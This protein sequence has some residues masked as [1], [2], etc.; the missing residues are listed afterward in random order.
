MHI[1]H[2]AG[3]FVRAIVQSASTLSNSWTLS[4]DGPAAMMK[5]VENL[6]A[7]DINGDLTKALKFLKNVPYEK[8]VRAQT[9]ILIEMV[10]FH[11]MD[12]SCS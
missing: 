12:A 3:L 6:G 11:S 1:I 5:L 2:R 10:T 7:K 8:I 4:E 9:V